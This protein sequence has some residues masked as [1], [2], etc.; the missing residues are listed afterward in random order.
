MINIETID[1]LYR[2][3][4]KYSLKEQIVYCDCGCINADDIKLLSSK[5]LRELSEDDI[6][7]YHGSAIYTVGYVEDYKFHLPRFL[8]LFAEKGYKS[9]I[10]LNDIHRKLDDVDWEKWDKEEVDV[11]NNFILEAWADY[12]NNTRI[13]IKLN[14]IEDFN[15]FIKIEDL[16]KLWDI[17]KSEESLYNFVEFFYFNGSQILNGGIKI[18]NSNKVNNFLQLIDNE[19]L[20]ELLETEFFK[21]ESS[22]PDYSERISIVLQMIEMEFKIRKSNSLNGI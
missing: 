5:P 1:N 9:I 8:E 4:R 3:F 12:S 10:D 16:V 21:F 20:L 19:N 2:V 17:T 15:L 22:D 14:I 6:S 13:G 18:N 7:W 11:I